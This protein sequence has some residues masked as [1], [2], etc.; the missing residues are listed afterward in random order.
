[1]SWPG[2]A[3]IPDVGLYDAD[4][5]FL[6]EEI[7]NFRE[8]TFVD[9]PG[10]MSTLGVSAEILGLTTHETFSPLVLAATLS[11]YLVLVAFGVS[12]VGLPTW[13][14][15]LF[16]TLGALSPAAWMIGTYTYLGNMLALPLFPAALLLVQS[17]MTPRIGAL[18]GL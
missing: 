4:S 17:G 2:T 14:A 15:A 6:A 7:R 8:G 16:A 12:V 13:M 11:L 18:A 9:K 10:T 1:V 3:V 5:G